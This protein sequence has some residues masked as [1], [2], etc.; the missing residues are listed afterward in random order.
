MVAYYNRL[1][2]SSKHLNIL[3]KFII[4]YLELYFKMLFV[5]CKHY[6]N[7]INNFEQIIGTPKYFF[8]FIL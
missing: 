8:Y 5:C 6:A 7:V 3:L 4:R 1:V 2:A